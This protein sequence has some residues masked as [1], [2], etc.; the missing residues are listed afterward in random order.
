MNLLRHLVVF[1]MD[2]FGITHPSARTERRAIWYISS[3]LLM[4]L[5][6]IGGVILAIAHEV[7]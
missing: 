2:T 1:F 5:L 6:L 4:V 7:K 3:L